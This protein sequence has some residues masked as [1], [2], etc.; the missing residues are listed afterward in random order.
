M[1]SSLPLLCYLIPGNRVAY[2]LGSG[3][4]GFGLLDISLDWNYASFFQP[5]YTPLW[6]SVSQIAGAVAVC[7]VIYPALYFANV[8]DSLKFPPMSSGIF[9]K[10][11]AE[12]NVSRVL[13][14]GNF[15]L[16]QG[17]ME[18]YSE[19]YWS[20]SYL[21]YFFWGFA[22]TTGVLVYA[23]L[24]YGKEGYTTIVGAWNGRRDN[25]DNDPY[26]KLMSHTDRVPHWWYVAL[27]AACFVLSLICLYA[28]DLGLSWWGLAAT[29][30][31]S[32]AFIF[33]GGI[34]FGLANMQVDLGFLSELLAGAMLRGNPAAVL[35][36][37]TYGRT[38]LEQV[39]PITLYMCRHRPVSIK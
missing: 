36:S 11:G 4:S 26:L 39:S 34:L 38:V 9:D 31:I 29:C 25:H 33:P 14:A 1:L 20:V 24:W 37:M 16:D 15:T 7:W 23:L 13:H 10:H 28:A 17:A 6:A 21:M 30:C 5:L 27:L 2:F 19:P 22:S 8:L 3:Y 18:A 32:A 35:V 12:Y